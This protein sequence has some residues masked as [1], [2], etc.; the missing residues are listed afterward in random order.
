MCVRTVI[1]A[2]MVEKSFQIPEFCSSIPVIS[3][4]YIEHLLID[5]S[6]GK[7]KIKNKRPGMVHF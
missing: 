2:P 6:I 3:K 7:T 1:V 5:N 4:I